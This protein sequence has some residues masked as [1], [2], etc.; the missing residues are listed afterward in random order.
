MIGAKTLS[1]RGALQAVGSVAA[2]IP[3]GAMAPLRP[4]PDSAPFGDVPICRVAD[5][6]AAAVGPAKKLK[7]TWNANAICTVGVPV[8]DQRGIFARH[9]LEVELVNFGGSTDQLLEAISTGK[10]D[11]GIG[12]A[13]RWLKPL[14]QG[15]DVKITSAIHGGCMRLFAKKDSG[16]TSIA[17]LRGKQVGCSDMAAPDKNFLSIVAAKQGLDPEADITWRQ[18]PAD[19][20]GVALQKGEIQAFPGRPAGLGDPRTRRAV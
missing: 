7:L 5:T 8:A 16:I 10:A 3:V 2:L 1:R 14:E 11:A 15:F 6:Q 4:L 13:L 20:L 9:G 19:L 18:F 12:M 17:D